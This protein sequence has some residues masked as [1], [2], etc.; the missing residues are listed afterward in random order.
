MPSEKDAARRGSVEDGRRMITACFARAS[1]RCT[2]RTYLHF[3]LIFQEVR[4]ISKTRNQLQDKLNSPASYRIGRPPFKSSSR[5]G[6]G[7]PP[8]CSAFKRSSSL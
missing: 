5:F 6:N 1:Q 7:C 4:P 3:L 8:L 2:S